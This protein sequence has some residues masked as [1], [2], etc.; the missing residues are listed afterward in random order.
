M[1]KLILSIITIVLIHLT[2]LAGWIL[3]HRLS[4]PYNSEGSY[5]D[6]K[7]GVVYYQQAIE[8]YGLITLCLFFVTVWMAYV[9]LKKH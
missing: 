8:V 2:V 6:E 3:K 1:K 5:V 9:T 7:N 4:L